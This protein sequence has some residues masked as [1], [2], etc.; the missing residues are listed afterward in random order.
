MGRRCPLNVVGLWGRMPIAGRFLWTEKWLESGGSA[1]VQK[2][3]NCGMCPLTYFTYLI[4]PLALFIEQPTLCPLWGNG[5]E[6]LGGVMG[7]R[8]V[9]AGGSGRDT[10][11]DFEDG[12]EGPNLRGCA[13]IT[14]GNPR[15]TARCFVPGEA[16][17]P[18]GHRG[19]AGRRGLVPARGALLGSVRGLDGEVLTRWRGSVTSPGEATHAGAAGGG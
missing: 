14:R 1:D 17:D 19:G 16:S 3:D 10:I 4:F 9:L 15:I 5:P 12:Q 6:V 2:M 8:D 13:Q 11:L 18:L 7:G